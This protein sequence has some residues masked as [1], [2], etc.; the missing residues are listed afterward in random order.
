MIAKVSYKV[1]IV[2]KRLNVS[3][4]I[5]C[6]NS[7]S[8][9]ERALDSVKNQ[10]MVPLEVILVD[11]CGHDDLSKFIDTI[12]YKYISL[13]DLKL[14]VTEENG[15]AGTARNLGWNNA[16]GEYVAFL[17][18]DDSWL[19]EKLELQFQYFEKY[20]DLILL[21][22]NHYIESEDNK[23]VEENL[24]KT[25]DQY[26]EIDNFSQ[27]IKNRFA[28][29]TVILKRDINFRFKYSKRYS[30]DFLLWN[31]IVM[32]GL[33]AIVLDKHTCI[34]HKPMYGS[35]GLSSHMPKMFRGELSTY[36][37]LYK[38]GYYSYLSLYFLLIFS[39]IKY[40]RRLAK[41]R[42]NKL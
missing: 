25:E 9:I 34:Y 29:S 37:T 30:E 2:K 4:V 24:V 19:S 12:K 14:I 8:T 5:P 40:G 28:T 17:D 23:F 13:F 11:D 22:T 10:T 15:G 42:L 39:C 3:V 41:S 27:L 26:I 16:V 35:S 32:S 7:T 6:F 36:K 38:Q 21:G 20:S 18:S 31:Q 1:E 33:K